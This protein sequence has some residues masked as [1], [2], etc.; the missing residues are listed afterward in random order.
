MHALFWMPILFWTWH[1]PI[2]AQNYLVKSRSTVLLGLFQNYFDATETLKIKRSSSWTSSIKGDKTAYESAG[3]RR[4]AND[5]YP[6]IKP[7]SCVTCSLHLGRAY[8]LS[9]RGSHIN[10]IIS[11]PWGATTAHCIHSARLLEEMRNAYFQP[12]ASAHVH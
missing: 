9:T 4:D 11:A 10:T 6:I 5:H 2:K 3:I 1:I 7:P 12:T 8:I